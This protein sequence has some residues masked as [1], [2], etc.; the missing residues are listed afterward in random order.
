MADIWVTAFASQGVLGL[1]V[2]GLSRA[3]WTLQAQV[4]AVQDERVSDAKAVT[5]TVLRLVSEQHAA[6]TE[7]TAAVVDL[8]NSLEE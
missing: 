4:K 3:C 6:T 2:L 8:R 5:E 1:G 7:L